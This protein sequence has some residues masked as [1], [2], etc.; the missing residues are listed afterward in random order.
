M[1]FFEYAARLDDGAAFDREEARAFI[2]RILRE[3]Y[4][5]NS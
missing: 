4:L 2:E 3:R 5:A 1:P